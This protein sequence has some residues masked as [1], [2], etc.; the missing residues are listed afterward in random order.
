MQAVEGLGVFH[1]A[2]DVSLVSHASPVSYVTPSYDLRNFFH[3]FVG[4]LIKQLNQTTVAGMLDPDFLRSLDLPYAQ[5]ATIG[6]TITPGNVLTTQIGGVAIPYTV[7]A[8]DTT[9]T[10]LARNVAAAI[11]ATTNLSLVT[12]FSSLPL[13]QIVSASASGSVIT[14]D[15]IDP[16][17]AT[18][19]S[20]YCA[21]SAG[22]TET[23]LP[24]AT[25]ILWSVPVGR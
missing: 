15:S 2:D 1:N 13:N 4:D 18:G 22:A 21:V 12:E 19:F 14:I 3:P 24:A 6:G 20:L 7:T 23:S 8:A 5:T 9:L 25:I 10:L 16:S 11:N 17:G